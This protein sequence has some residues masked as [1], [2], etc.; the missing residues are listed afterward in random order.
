MRA[1]LSPGDGEGLVMIRDCD[2]LAPLLW[3]VLDGHCC[4]KSINQDAI[5]AITWPS[6]V[7]TRVSI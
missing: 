2:G 7:I 1:P 4:T 3:R 5:Y 6:Q